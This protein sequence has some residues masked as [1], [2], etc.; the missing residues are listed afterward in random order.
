MAKYPSPTD[1]SSSPVDLSQSDFLG[2]HVIPRSVVRIA[3]DQQK[4]LDRKEAWAYGICKRRQQLYLPPAVFKNLEEFHARNLKA[5]KS[6]APSPSPSQHIDG[7]RS[8]GVQASS[9]SIP[10]TP[11]KDKAGIDDDGNHDD[12][13]DKDSNDERLSHGSWTPSPEHHLH[14]PAARSQEPEQ[15]E[16]EREEIL[17][18]PPPD[19]SP[20]RLSPS[21]PPKRLAFEKPPSSS[22]GPDNELELEIP[23]ALDVSV[24]PVENTAQQ[25]VQ[26]MLATPPSAQVIPCTFEQPDLSS[27]K[28]HIMREN[29]PRPVYKKI[30]ELYRPPKAAPT[31]SFGLGM[32]RL[33]PTK[34]S[35][36]NTQISTSTT[37]TSSS[38]I[39]PATHRDVPRTTSNDDSSPESSHNPP[40]LHENPE[41]PSVKHIEANSSNLDLPKSPEP[42]NRNG[43][44]EFIPPSPKLKPS[45]PPPV[46][47]VQAPL[48][49]PQS[50]KQ[51]EAP[52]IEFT[53]NYPGYTGSIGDFVTACVYLQTLAGRRRLRPFLFDEFIRAW[54]EGYLPYVRE[55]DESDPPTKAL[56][57]LQWFNEIEDPPAFTKQVV[58]TAALERILSFYPEEALSARGKPRTPRQ[59][60]PE[61]AT[62]KGKQVAK[63]AQ[64]IGTAASQAS[65]KSSAPAI[66]RAPQGGAGSSSVADILEEPAPEASTPITVHPAA[67]QATPPPA[68]ALPLNKSMDEVRREKR[69]G[70]TASELPRSLSEAATATT[71]HKRKPSGGDDNN[72]NGFQVPAPKKKALSPTTSTTTTTATVATATAGKA[73]SVAPSRPTSSSGG[74]FHS[75]G[76]R[77]TTTTTGAVSSSSGV[78]VGGKR[79]FG[80]DPEKRKRRLA[81]FAKKFREQRKNS[82]S[83][84][85]SSAPVGGKP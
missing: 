43:S 14:P 12:E 32:T 30:P 82:D 53:L 15:E 42:R 81:R 10:K 6:K 28:Q 1:E 66:N 75:D 7:G 72:N 26:P 18:Q 52:F 45:S 78:V 37:D 76:S 33:G 49:S 29:K 79:R 34:P 59:T 64:P 21:P 71:S 8:D 69:P 83:I 4:L 60:T 47:T 77:S 17:T 27:T 56:N 5:Q 85:T 73:A 38:S 31:T 41:L 58:T 24:A 36:I 39:V 13:D 44:P 20:P 55:C 11:Q 16:S 68:R 35:F 25:L 22:P 67:H 63:G 19:S 2:E 65:L 48:L 54:S 46:T 40:E 61:A 23:S 70:P 57:A 84:V 80:D 62:S 9:A 50:V 3:K 51:P 74:S